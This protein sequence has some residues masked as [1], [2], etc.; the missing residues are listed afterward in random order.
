VALGLADGC[1]VL[2]GPQVV[3]GAIDLPAP[4]LAELPGLLG[5]GHWEMTGGPNPPW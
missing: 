4:G 2:L 5:L 3:L 1:S